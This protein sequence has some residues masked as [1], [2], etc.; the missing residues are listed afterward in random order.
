MPQLNTYSASAGSGKTFILT[1]KYIE[2]L[3]SDS[4]AYKSILAVTFTNKA[5]GEMKDR[6][7]RDLYFLSLGKDQNGNILEINNDLCKKFNITP[8]ETSKRASRILD[9]ILN[10]YSRFSVGTIDKFFQFIIRSFARETGLQASYN[11]ELN[12]QN[13]LRE[14]TDNLLF[15]MD[16]DETLRHWLIQFA[17][18]LVMEGKA[19]NLKKEIMVLGDELFK[20]SYNSLNNQYDNDLIND[21]KIRE[22]SKLLNLKISGF[23]NRMKNIGLNFLEIIR[24]HNL[25][26]ADFK[27]GSRTFLNYFN[28][29]TNPANCDSY[30]LKKS[31]REAIDQPVCWYLEKSIKKDQIINAYENGLNALLKET[32]QFIDRNLRDYETACVI[33]RF[34]YAFGIL[35][36]LSKQIRLITTER[37]LFLLSDSSQF[38]NEIIGDNEAPFIYEKTGIYFK[39]FMLD[40]F[41]D[42]S[43]FQWNNF[44]PL[45]S[46]SLAEGNDNLIVGDIKQSIYR[47]RNSD[48]NILDSSINKSFPQYISE[49]SLTENWRSL[50]NIVRFNNHIFSSSTEILKQKYIEGLPEMEGNEPQFLH[51]ADKIISVYK[52]SEQ[53]V[54]LK[55]IKNKGYV[56]LS[57]LPSGLNKDESFSEIKTWLPQTLIEIQNRGFKAKDI[58]ILV[59]KGIEGN[60]IASFL[61]EF[62]NSIDTDPGK[63]N[64]NVISNDSLFIS[65]NHAVQLLVSLIRH[66]SLSYDD[67]NEAFIRHEFFL[68]FHPE[69]QISDN[70]HSIFDKSQ[71]DI[72]NPFIKVINNFFLEHG[73]NLQLSIFEF[74]ENLIRIFR[75]NENIQDLPYIQAFQDIILNFMKK[76][77]SDINSFLEF[78]DDTGSNETLNISEQ[79]DAI[80]IMTIHKAK[81]LEFKVVIIPFC[82]WSI[83]NDKGNKTNILWCKTKD[84]SF[85]F[86]PFV[87]VNCSG[88]LSKTIFSSEYQVERLNTYIDNLN[89]LYVSFTRAEQELYVLTSPTKE[90]KTGKSLQHVGDILLNI[91]EN[92]VTEEICFE[93]QQENEYYSYEYG[94]PEIS[95]STENDKNITE[96]FD[97]YPVKSFKGKLKVKFRG[98]DLIVRESGK[99][100][101]IEYGVVMHEILSRLKNRND[102]E[103]SVE[104]AYNQGKF[105]E[106]GKTEIR[107]TLENAFK[108]NSQFEMFPEGWKIYSERTLITKT[109]EYRPDRVM[110]KG[111]SAIIIDFKFGKEIISSHKSQVRDYMNYIRQTGIDNTKGYI[112]Y[113]TLEKV[114][115]IGDER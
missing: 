101:S 5:A 9:N 8:S 86:L 10:D 68:Y 107:N 87:P 20:E 31:H 89:L 99:L 22:Y 3:F 39:N 21:Q 30:E 55:G 46:N 34:I 23:E 59:R 65:N 58:A 44:E 100:G 16:N 77:T 57:F 70:Y 43:L 24:S 74:V 97:Y 25:E 78:W 62:K 82:N 27:G 112:W 13:V 1:K 52:N 92:G 115:E 113:L 15:E 47:W 49:I 14:A 37:N 96:I 38:L 104:I 105:D 61:S 64:F 80:R 79:Q 75:L 111:K 90:S 98:D 109:G 51:L 88:K 56:K 11:L 4:S 7:L 83:E 63:Y 84:S 2:L 50:E 28:K 40:E 60:Q 95:Y 81:G 69:N 66:F 102:I 91:V 35:T 29:I 32:G 73:S 54:P 26:L 42:T 19:F 53:T 17:E 76:E 71:T 114:E 48:W 106:N 18:E 72:D 93:K 12:N 36:D 110:L 67:I 108:N 103:R 45:I 6:I 85:D 94:S 41:Q 33:N